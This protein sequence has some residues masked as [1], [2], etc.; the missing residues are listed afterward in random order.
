MRYSRQ[1]ILP[2]MGSLGQKKLAEAKVAVIG[3]GGLG[4]PLLT[5]LTLAG[6][7][8]IKFIDHDLVSESNLNRQFLHQEKDLGKRKVISAREKLQP[9]NSKLTLTPLELYI[10]ESNAE[11]ALQGSDVIVS[12]VDNLGQGETGMGKLIQYDGKSL[13]LD[14]V[15]LFIDSACELHKKYGEG[16]GRE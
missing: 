9:L 15:D 13:T 16:D 10:G 1:T 5:Y 8:K 6:V 14:S 12:C 3:V 4:S 7:G 11:K 2:E